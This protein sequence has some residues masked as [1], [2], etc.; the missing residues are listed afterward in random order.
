MPEEDEISMP[1]LHCNAAIN[2]SRW[3]KLGE[4]TNMMY[5]GTCRQTSCSKETPHQ[6]M[7]KWCY[8]YSLHN[9]NPPG[10]RG[11][12]RQSGIYRNI[13]SARQ[14]FT[15]S[16]HRVSASLQQTT[17]YALDQSGMRVEKDDCNISLDQITVNCVEDIFEQS[18]MRVEKDDYNLSLDQVTVNCGE[19]VFDQSAQSASRIDF[20]NQCGFDKESKAPAFYEFLYANEGKGAQY[21]TAKAFTVDVEK[22]S[23]AEARFALLMAMLLC[24]LTQ[25]QHELLAQILSYAAN[26]SDSKKSIFKTTRVATTVED[27]NDLYITGPNSILSNLPVPVAKSTPDKLHAYVTLSDVL[28]NEFAA[29]TTFDSFF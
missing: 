9:F 4:N 26:A 12:G 23:V 20:T 17:D 3:T 27:F 24:Q 2:C 8:E 25:A 18:G 13:R 11:G 22:V 14:H 16:T 21:L 5:R 1:C 15:S 29:G 10:R 28:A 6:Y 19:D 7:C